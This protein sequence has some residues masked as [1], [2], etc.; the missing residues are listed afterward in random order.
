MI[1]CQRGDEF[2]EIQAG[3]VLVEIW[4]R[5]IENHKKTGSFAEIKASEVDSWRE[6]RIRGYY[7]F[8]TSVERD[9]FSAS[10]ISE[11]PMVKSLYIDE[12]GTLRKTQS[13]G[14]ASEESPPVR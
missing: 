12:S 9:K 4:R 6:R 10:A 1:G 3:T 11:D 2:P 7:R 5:E 8:E 14:P 13:S